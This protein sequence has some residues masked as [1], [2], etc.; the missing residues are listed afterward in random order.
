M[1]DLD[2]KETLR[3]FREYFARGY[4]AQYK[5]AARIGI[6]FNTLAF[7]L[8]DKVKPKARTIARL[9]VFLDADAK[10]HGDGNGIRPIER[11]PFKIVKPAKQER[12]ARVC[13][14]CRK[15]RDKIR[16]MSRKWFQGVCPKCRATGPKRESHQEALRA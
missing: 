13:P 10:R 12:Y 1:N 15:A 14:F 5:L 6:D 4:E 11:V 7:V 16:S 3:E 2:P 9:R 8:A